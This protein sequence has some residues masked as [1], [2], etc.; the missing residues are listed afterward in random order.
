MKSLNTT[1]PIFLCAWNEG[2]DFEIVQIH[3]SQSFYDEFKS[4]NLFSDDAEE[5]LLSN[6]EALEVGDTYTNDNM[7]VKR[8]N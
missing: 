1:Q 5:D 8:I 7:Q 6:F 3:T 2:S 4:T